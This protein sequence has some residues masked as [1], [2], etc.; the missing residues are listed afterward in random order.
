[1][2]NDVAMR[3]SHL[4]KN[5][6]GQTAL[7]DFD[8]EIM[9]GEIRGLIGENGAGKSTFIKILAGIHEESAGFIE[10]DGKKSTA[11]DRKNKIA[12]VHQDLG[13]IDTLSIAENIGFSI[14]FPMRRGFIDWKTCDEFAINAYKKMDLDAPDPARKVGTLSPAEK[15]ILGIVRALSRD[16]SIMVLDEPTSSLTI[17]DFH[18]LHVSLSKLKKKGLSVIY[19]THKLQEIF[20][21]CDSVTILREGKKVSEGS[22]SE[23][24]IQSF[25]EHMLGRK[26]SSNSDH[27]TNYANEEAI[28]R[29]TDLGT[30]ENTITLDINKNE[31][32]GLVGL[33]GAGHEMFAR[34]LTGDIKASKGSVLIHG[35]E[36]NLA[37]SI[38]ARM[39]SK[40]S[41]LPADRQRESTFPGMTLVENLFPGG[42]N[43]FKKLSWIPLKRERDGTTHEIEKYDVRPPHPDKL[44]D[45][46]S[47]GNQQKVVIARVFYLQQN[48][49]ILEEPTA[50]VDVGSKFQIHEFVREAANKGTAVLLI[51]SDFEEVA[52]LCTRVLVMSQGL[53]R[54]ELRGSE[55]SSDRLT[56]A[57]SLV[58]T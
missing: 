17:P 56:F 5:F 35:E 27:Q 44:I 34:M 47:G 6:T 43:R 12:F 31:I 38:P 7:S 21:V 51:S 4:T 57:A 49:V 20:D 33:R 37:T 2:N 46:L 13:L 15:T 3:V 32:L 41:L 25:V 16:V 30:D 14:G 11:S 26:L 45:E 52:H 9:P 8:F 28:I 1:M 24:T 39:K 53:V 58:R 29:V 36:I 42:L 48:L 54:E 18:Y 22:L 23:Y 10:L 50:G 19:V 55:I 40:I